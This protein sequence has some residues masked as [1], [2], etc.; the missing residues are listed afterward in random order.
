MNTYVIYVP[1]EFGK[2]KIDCSKIMFIERGE[3]FSKVYYENEKNAELFI[4]INEAELLLFDQ[5]FFRCNNDF[6][7]NLRFVQ[8]LFPA[9]SSKIILESGKE[10]TVEPDKRN[11]MFDKLCEVFEFYELVS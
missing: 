10:I 5:G 7:V 3:P 11:E 6:L 1:T 2:I 4:T 9:N 8:L